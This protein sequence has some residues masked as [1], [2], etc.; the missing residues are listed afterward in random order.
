M[1]DKNTQTT[2][3][4]AYTQLNNDLFPLQNTYN[5]KSYNTNYLSPF[6]KKYK[7]KEVDAFNQLTI[8][9]AGDS[10]LGRQD[11]GASWVEAN[12]E[13]DYTPD[14][15]NPAETLKGY[16]TG[17]FPPNMWEQNIQYKLLNLL[18]FPEADVKYYNHT[19][20]EVVKAGTVTNAFPAG[21]DALRTCYFGDSASVSL[22][23]TN[24]KFCKFIWTGY[25][26]PSMLFLTIVVSISDDG[27][28]TWK[29][30][31]QLSLTESIANNG[32]SGQY[33]CPNLSYK[34]GQLI[35][36]NFDKT[37]SYIVKVSRLGAGR[38]LGVWGFET[39]SNK[40]INIVTSAEGGNVASQQYANYYRFYSSLFSP[41]LI[42]YELPYLNDL[43]TGLIN[44]YKG[45]AITS[46]SPSVSPVLNDFYYASKN[47]IYTNFGSITAK[48]GQYLQYN[49]STWEIGST[50]V[51]TVLANYA[52][53]NELVFKRL[54]TIG[55]PVLTLITHNAVSFLTKYFC[56][57]EGLNTLRYLVNIYG[58]A[59]LDVNLYQM[60]TNQST[61]VQADGTHLNN[62]GVGMYINCISEL[63]NTSYTENS[64][65]PSNNLKQKTLTG[66]GNG[67]ATVAFGYELSSIPVIR[68]YNSS[69]ITVTATTVSSFT[70]TGTGSYIWEAII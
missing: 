44:N 10:I 37:K 52:T 26:I 19:A 1:L 17:H 65:C 66:N 61:T 63:L 39:W 69:T 4:A 64:A 33:A 60:K 20:S 11:K 7:L 70:V 9:C 51:N 16:Q 14:M 46:T 27:G 47:G 29:T 5:N 49:G 22:T 43:G 12:P 18:Q 45:V 42:I 28:S 38:N 30:P 57:N 50:T 13:L 15:N 3:E 35:F 32:T 31:A 55:V 53:Q 59:S 40:R 8:M 23:F 36:G 21:S 48:I 62:A 25:A 68:I 6:L 54:S 24:A 34:F 41:A 56:I 67:A 58:F 2:M